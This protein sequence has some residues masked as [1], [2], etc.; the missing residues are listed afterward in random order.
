M[1]DSPQTPPDV[2]TDQFTVAFGPY[3]ATINYSLSSP[4]MP[5]VGTPQQAERVVTVRM[6]LQHLKHMAFILQKQIKRY[7]RD[8]GTNIQ[9]PL[10]VLNQT[11]IGPEDWESFWRGEVDPI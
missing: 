8:T 1:P 6:S 10:A 9:V 7:E 11:Q 5:Q 3:G 2:Y 4:A